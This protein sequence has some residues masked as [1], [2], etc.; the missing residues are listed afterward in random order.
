MNDNPYESPLT[1]GL[2]IYDYS[3]FW[4]IVKFFVW[5][6]FIMAAADLV[7]YMQFS[8]N[9]AYSDLPSLIRFFLDFDSFD[10]MFRTIL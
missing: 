2:G 10:E 6:S 9:S 4:R 1:T 3:L 7:L 5:F 8:N